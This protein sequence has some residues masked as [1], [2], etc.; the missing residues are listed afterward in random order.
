M[1]GAPNIL[2]AAEPGAA[3]NIHVALV[4]FGK[5]AEVLFDCLRNI[6]GLHFQAV[7][8]ISDYNRQQRRQPGPRA[9]RDTPPKG[10]SDIDDMLAT[11]KGLDAVSRRHARLLAFARTP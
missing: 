9:S 7:C 5:Q 2:R 1:L 6:P 11:E 8:D 4:G 10:Y 3:D